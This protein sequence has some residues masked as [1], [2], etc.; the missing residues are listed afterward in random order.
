MSTIDPEHP[1]SSVLAAALLRAWICGDVGRVK[2][3]LKR[4]FVDC[5]S[6]EQGIEMEHRL[7]LRAIVARMQGFSD[8]FA[9]RRTDPALDLCIDLLIHLAKRGRP[10]DAAAVLLGR[11]CSMSAAT[12]TRG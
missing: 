2:T 7:L 8:W 9:P 12:P 10:D 11:D 1:T 5:P 3:E 6:T 4:S